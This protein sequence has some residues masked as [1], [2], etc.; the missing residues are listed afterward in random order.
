MLVEKLIRRLKG[1]P[2]YQWESHYAPRDLMVIMWGRSRQALRGSWRSLFFKKHSGLA[3]IGT[4]VVIKHSY[5][6]AAGQNLILEDNVY[7][8]ALSD[9]G[10][11]L[12]NNV[13]LARNCS[14]ICTG[15]I[16]QKGK[17]ISIGNNSGINAGVFLGGQGGIEIGDNVIIGPGTKIFSENHNYAAVDVNI[18]D[19]GVSR[20]GVR[21]GN[22]CWV[23]A[24]VTILAGVSIGEGCVIAAGS[25]VTKSIAPN[26]VVAGIPGK[27]LKDRVPN[28]NYEDI[29]NLHIAV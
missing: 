14:M 2:N 3:F 4:N 21:I 11:N 20:S 24:N 15:V 1:N 17:G 22:N 28:E 9:D 10:I 19:Q 7:I 5:L 18:K 29:I 16:A 13:T 23:G 25:V 6:L 27:K 12:K 8:N 26:S